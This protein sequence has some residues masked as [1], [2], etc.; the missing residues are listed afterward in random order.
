MTIL[1]V[2][3]LGIIGSLIGLIGSFLILKLIFALMEYSI[4]KR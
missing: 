2:I 1:I 4:D 3:F